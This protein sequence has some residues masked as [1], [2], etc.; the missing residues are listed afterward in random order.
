M[1]SLAIEMADCKSYGHIHKAGC[2]DLRDPEPLGQATTTA[3]ATQLAYDL[4]GWEADEDGF[5]FAP[6]A[7]K[8]LRK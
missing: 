4:T 3:Q 5:H 1:T 6:C 2:R 8:S 7:R